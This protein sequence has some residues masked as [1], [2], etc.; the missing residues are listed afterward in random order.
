MEILW[1]ANTAATKHGYF[2][3]PE[4]MVLICMGFVLHKNVKWGE[5]KWF[6]KIGKTKRNLF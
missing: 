4:R 5:H 1:K 2:E 6:N 3:G